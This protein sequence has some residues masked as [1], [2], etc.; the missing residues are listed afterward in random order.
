MILPDRH[1]TKRVFFAALLWLGSFSACAGDKLTV[2]TVNYPLQYFA[3]RIAGKH[4]EVHFPAPADVDPAFWKPDP[5]TIRQY[6]AADLI[7]LNGAGYASWVEEAA[8]PRSRQVDTSL[9]FAEAYITLEDSVAR[10]H[11]SDAKHA[12]AG[13]AYTTWLDFYQA[14]QQAQAVMQALAEK[15]PQY[16]VQF[17]RNYQALKQEL[18]ALDLDMQRLVAQHP[19]KPLFVSQ[20]LYQYFAR[21]YEL[22]LQSVIW[23]PDVMAAEPDWEQL[24]FAQEAFPATLMIWEEQP[25]AQIS[26]RLR[27]LGISVVVFHP[28]ANRL[29]Q[30]DFMQVMRRNLENLKTAVAAS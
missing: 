8:L 15:R 4:A 26:E 13:T 12:H 2:Y 25:V 22:Q 21:R 30:G 28:C 9:S 3:E 18:M 6:H 19:A 27:S 7:L 10:S 1:A 17:E 11:T 5:E 24:V 20:P 16:E 29:P 14:A 23:D